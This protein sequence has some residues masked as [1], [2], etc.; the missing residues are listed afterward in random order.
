MRKKLGSVLYFKHS[1]HF[2]GHYLRNSVI[3]VKMLDVVVPSSH[4]EYKLMQDMLHL[5]EGTLLDGT[6]RKI[7]PYGAQVRI[8][9][10]NRRYV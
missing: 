2:L 6:I 7:F 1:S 9:E 5:K 4:S 8:G 10:T 3:R